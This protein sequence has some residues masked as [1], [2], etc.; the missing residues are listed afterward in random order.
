ME[1]KHRL[2]AKDYINFNLFQIQYSKQTRR[3]LK[4]QRIVLTFLFVLMA[5]LAFSLLSRFNLT[6]AAIFLLMAVLW[7]L[8]FPSFTKNRV[9]KSTEKTIG[10]GQLPTLFDEIQ[11]AFDDEGIKE[12]STQGEQMNLWADIQS[13]S[14]TKKYFYLFITDTIAI[15]L[16]KRSMTREEFEQLE[17]LIE[18]NYGASINERTVL[19]SYDED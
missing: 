8:N 17:I 11:L 15:I 7:Y 3:R 2:E 18:R 5:L 14:R 19:F 13:I 12:V 6:A 4:I 1:I 16:P 10:G 9:I